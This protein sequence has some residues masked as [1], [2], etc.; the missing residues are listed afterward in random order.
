MPTYESHTRDPLPASDRLELPYEIRQKSRALVRL[1]SGL[2][3]GVFLT[4]GTILRGG[5][6]LLG[7]DGSVVEVVAAPEE[8]LEVTATDPTDLLRAA[9]HLGNRHVVLEVAP[10]RLRLGRDSVLA[11]MLAQLGGLVVEERLEPFEPEAGAY[12]GHSHSHERR[13]IHG[14]GSAHPS[15]S[16][17]IH[18]F[19]K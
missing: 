18:D 10:G 16:A 5:D 2:E 7:D 19:L 6:R 11:A 3:A 9:Y 4:P 15:G 8:I 1:E 17:R 13:A 14:P 12:G